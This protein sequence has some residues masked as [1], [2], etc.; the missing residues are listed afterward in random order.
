MRKLLAL[1]FTL[2][3]FLSV[4]G[5][6]AKTVTINTKINKQDITKYVETKL[7]TSDHYS[8]EGFKKL[9]TPNISINYTRKYIWLKFSILN[10]AEDVISK[11]LVLEFLSTDQIDLYELNNDN[12]LTHIERTGGWTNASDRKVRSLIP[13]IP[14][15]IDAHTTK[16]FVIRRLGLQRLDGRISIETPKSFYHELEIFRAINLLFAG[17]MLFLVLFHI[18]FWIGQPSRDKFY[19]ILFNV[20]ITGVTLIFSGLFN[21]F[22]I[23]IFSE[24][25]PDWLTFFSTGATVS[26]ILFAK[27]FIFKG[28]KSSFD[29]W[30]NSLAIMLFLSFVANTFFHNYHT[31][32]LYLTV[33]ILIGISVLLIFIMPLSMF[34]QTIF[35]R[36]HFLSWFSIVLSITGYYLYFF[37]IFTYRQAIYIL[38]GG[39]TVETILF[40]FAISFRYLMVMKERD[41][42]LKDAN[43]KMRLQNLNRVLF[44]DVKNRLALIY[45]RFNDAFQEQD[46]AL[47]PKPISL[48][49]N[50]QENLAQIQKE[51]LKY[52]KEGFFITLDSAVKTIQEIF[53]KEL[54]HKKVSI[55]LAGKTDFPL[56]INK[57]ILINSILSNLISN[58]IKFSHPKGK[59]TIHGQLTEDEYI[60]SIKDRGVGIEAKVLE[61]INSGKVITTPGTENEEGTGLGLSIVKSYMQEYKGSL[62]IN[63]TY[64]KG[65]EVQLVLPKTH[66]AI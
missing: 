61:D 13:A 62:S 5:S 30:V 63:S 38:M 19:Y 42:A 11:M 55:Q 32:N 59:I 21:Y 43:E 52:E 46:I 37:D 16:T 14:I 28:E 18:V 27:S 25:I 26:A 22:D 49:S 6:F 12:T 34:K 24:S 4:S 51:E 40:S 65:T 56:Y 60:F 48:L 54:T 10:S 50:L 64:K 17:G 45:S 33:D 8:P 58:A 44:H 29:K 15:T 53:A 7:T 31:G 1:F 23:T 2:T 47:I 35:A 36:L 3:L 41:Q 39:S 57:N 66:S 9:E 20:L